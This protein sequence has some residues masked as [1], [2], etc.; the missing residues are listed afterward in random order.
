[1][2]IEEVL[3]W[4]SLVTRLTANCSPPI[5]AATI[6]AIIAMESGGDPN[7]INE[8]M[9][10]TGLMQV[11]PR[12]AN[13]GI[14]GSRPPQKK[15]LDPETNIRWGIRILQW[16]LQ[17]NRSLEEGLYYYS[18][19]RYWGNLQKYQDTYWKPFLKHRET[20][21]QHLEEQPDV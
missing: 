9:G 4:T 2:T 14:F 10:A 5:D 19:G 13:P 3:I 7:A 15:L 20:I 6:L 17:G 18:G 16:S 11:M 1:M 8:A 12:E 21:R